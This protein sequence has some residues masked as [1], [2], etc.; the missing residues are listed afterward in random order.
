M[1]QIKLC[2]SALALHE[3]CE[4]IQEQ[5]NSMVC[6]VKLGVTQSI[7][8]PEELSVDFHQWVAAPYL[9]DVIK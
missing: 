8:I 6:V 2:C 9:I 7:E 5:C 1:P 3:L 4:G